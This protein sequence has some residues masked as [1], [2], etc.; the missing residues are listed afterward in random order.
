MDGEARDQLLEFL[1]MFS[2]CIGGHILAVKVVINKVVR[3]VDPNEE[4]LTF[5][6][7]FRGSNES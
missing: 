7:V 1:I 3:H 5:R 2:L 4:A 6:D